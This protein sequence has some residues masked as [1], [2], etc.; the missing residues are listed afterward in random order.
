MKILSF[1]RFFRGQA[2]G[3]EG[4]DDQSSKQQERPSDSFLS[5]ERPISAGNQPRQTPG[6]NRG[7]AQPS[8]NQRQFFFLRDQPDETAEKRNQATRQP[9]R[10]GGFQSGNERPLRGADYPQQPAVN[11]RRFPQAADQP[12]FSS[13]GAAAAPLGANAQTLLENLKN[14]DPGVQVVFITSNEGRLAENT[15]ASFSEK[16]RIGAS[17]AISLAVARKESIN[18]HLGEVKE[19]QIKSDKGSIL[20]LSLGARGV[21]TIVAD[22]RADTER[23]LQESHKVVNH[24]MSMR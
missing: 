16:V 8:D 19:L 12:Q 6:V 4:E 22:Q 23:V 14:L 1:F 9:G 3:S 11:S 7:S 15:L 5:G 10:L 13:G 18:L 17:S 21:L 2:D 24:L 20:L